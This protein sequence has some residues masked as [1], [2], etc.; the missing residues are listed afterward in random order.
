MP[1]YSYICNTCGFEKDFLQK[2]SDSPISICENCGS[3]NF[4][5]KL[6]AAGFQLKGTGWYVTDFKNNVK[7]EEK[8]NDV[9]LENNNEKNKSNEKKA[10]EKK[11]NN[12]LKKEKSKNDLKNRNIN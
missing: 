11:G 6:T 3:K 7:K 9:K 12:I 2:I 1:I 5:K 4:K 8:N 10:L